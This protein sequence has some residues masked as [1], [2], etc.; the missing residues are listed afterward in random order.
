MHAFLL[1][2]VVVVI[3]QAALGQLTP[4]IQTVDKYELLNTGKYGSKLYQ[5]KMKNS[6]YG[7]NEPYL[8]NLTGDSYEA[9]YDTG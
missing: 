6:S 5:L 3:L 7:N 2:I 4:K 9:G 8:L 1:L